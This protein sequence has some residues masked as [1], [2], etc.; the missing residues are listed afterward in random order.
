MR[1]IN[2]Y[3]SGSSFRG[4][5]SQEMRSTGRPRTAG[6][7][8]E[9]LCSL[10]RTRR[11]PSQSRGYELLTAPI[12]ALSQDSVLFFPLHRTSFTPCLGVPS[13]TTSP[14]NDLFL[15]LNY[16]YIFF[17]L[18]GFCSFL[19]GLTRPWCSVV[20]LLPPGFFLCIFSLLVQL[21]LDSI[22]INEIRVLREREYA[23]LLLYL[24]WI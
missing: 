6:R 23:Y 19:L 1:G 17:L 7:Q 14:E 21:R 15:S 3:S 9:F 22:C 12:L 13:V 8:E 5:P 11:L 20:P 10:E 2:K 4:P 16:I 24:L 18:G